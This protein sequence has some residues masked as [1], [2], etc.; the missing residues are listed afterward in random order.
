M[1]CTVLC[2]IVVLFVWC[3]TVIQQYKQGCNNYW[4]CVDPY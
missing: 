4:R 1:E 3:D 2:C